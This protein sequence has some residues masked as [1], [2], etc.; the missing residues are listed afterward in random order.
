MS[1]VA[2][3]YKLLILKGGNPL[4]RIKVPEKSIF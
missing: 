3:R 4:N 1:Y 2:L